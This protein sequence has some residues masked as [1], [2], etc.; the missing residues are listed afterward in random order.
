M[1]HFD[2]EFAKS[3]SITSLLE[4]RKFEDASN[5]R[6]ARQFILNT[7]Q[8]VTNIM[9]SDFVGCALGLGRASAAGGDKLNMRKPCGIRN[10]DCCTAA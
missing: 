5:Q 7:G 4:R 8:A 10:A 3:V 2:M 6:G 9:P 1:R